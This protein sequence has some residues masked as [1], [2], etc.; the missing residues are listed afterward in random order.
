MNYAEKWPAFKNTVLD[1]FRSEK[2]KGKKVA[3]YGAGSST[4]CLLSFLGLAPY[5]DLILDDQQ[6]KQDMFS[7]DTKLPI[8]SGEELYK[9][10]IDVCFLAVNVENEHKV[11]SKHQKWVDGGGT[12][13]SLIPPSYLL[14]PFWKN[15]IILD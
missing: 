14:P 9:S 10:G 13:W 7:P 11:I 1:Y 12:F 8:V 3:I 2:D 6:E 5:I 15:F 4:F